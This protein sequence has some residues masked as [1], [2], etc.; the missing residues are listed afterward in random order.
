MFSQ[1]L[2]GVTVHKENLHILLTIGSN[3]LI[4]RKADNRKVPACG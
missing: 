1:R 2:I 4:K 3:S